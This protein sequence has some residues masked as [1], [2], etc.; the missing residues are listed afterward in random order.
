MKSVLVE[1]EKL[2][3]PY[4]GLG[5]FCK[6]IG[7][8]FQKLNPPDL[9]LDFY[10][11]FSQTGIFGENF[12]YIKHSPL[13]K[14]FF[15]NS[16]KYDVWHCT[17][18]DSRYFPFDRNTKI[19]LT[20][21]DLNFLGKY[22]GWR[23]EK[24]LYRLQKLVN[25]ASAITVISAFTEKTARENLQLS[26]KPVRV[27][28]NGNSLKT[29]EN[30]KRPQ[31]AAFDNFIFTVGIISP[32]KNFRTLLSLLENDKQLNLVIAGVN[33]TEYARSIARHAHQTGIEKQLYMPGIIS[34]EEKFW[35]YKNC[36]AFVFPSLT[37]G[38]GL[39]VV[40]AM[41]LGKPCFLSNLTSLPEIGGDEAFYWQD[42]EPQNMIDVFEK[43]LRDF[44]DERARRSVIWAERFS[45]EK[46]ADAYLKLYAEI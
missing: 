20:V 45:W 13:H 41:S 10:L 6:N 21:H 2:K 36:R 26:D 32:K 17:H 9:Q 38:F 5:Q 22:K 18:Q 40:E 33:N 14:L 42:F 43:G 27:I 3:N 8:Q 12:R 37:E 35:F 34:D 39:P 23:R 16:P 15:I 24:K 19:I 31:F 1:M 25:K 7:E 44:D 46:A 28:Y 4:S 29:F 30:V 11:P